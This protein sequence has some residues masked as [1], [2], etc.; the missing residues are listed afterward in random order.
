MSKYRFNSA[1]RTSH[2]RPSLS[3]GNVRPRKCLNT[4]SREIPSIRAT[5]CGRKNSR[6]SIF[7]DSYVDTTQPPKS[8]RPDRGTLEAFPPGVPGTLLCFVLSELKGRG[9]PRVSDTPRS[10]WTFILQP[11]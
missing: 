6:S 11:K 9:I 10:K 3:P 1:V 2:T 8:V 4:C 7:E 5:S